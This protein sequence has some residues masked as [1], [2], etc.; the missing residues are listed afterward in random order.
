MVFPDLCFL[1]DRPV[2]LLASESPPPGCVALGCDQDVGSE[3]V[4]M[5]V[6][7]RRRAEKGDGWQASR[8]TQSFL[9]PY[10]RRGSSGE[11]RVRWADQVRGR[12]SGRGR[13][14]VLEF[15]AVD[16][17]PRVDHVHAAV[18][19]AEDLPSDGKGQA[20]A[21]HLGG[22][23]PEDSPDEVQ[24]APGARGLLEPEVGQGRMEISHAGVDADDGAGRVVGTKRGRSSA[25]TSP[26]T[27]SGGGVHPASS[28]D[29]KKSRSSLQSVARVRTG[30]VDQP[31]PHSS[32]KLPASSETAAKRA[33][34]SRL[35]SV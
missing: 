2:V 16:P 3:R 17:L 5:R 24:R 31:R 20:T 27:P 14:R 29:K 32:L 4:D 18:R 23:Q 30:R 12:E 11:K 13:G 19:P 7:V 35:P 22:S 21:T 33:F 8:A 34:I 6:L 28:P 10:Y 25:S 1:N 9:K 26:Q 15:K